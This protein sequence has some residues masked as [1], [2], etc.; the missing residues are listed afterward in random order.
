MGKGRMRP[1]HPRS[2]FGALAR[3]HHVGR[4]QEMSAADFFIT[5]GTESCDD[6]IAMLVEEKEAITVRHQESVGPALLTGARGR[7]KGL[8]E[9]IARGCSQAAQ[10]AIA[11][12][13][14]DRIALEIRRADDAVQTVRQTRHLA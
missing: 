13:A 4:L 9:A 12:H 10:L 8:P 2:I 1:E 11:A 3:H 14:V 7:L 5:L 6:Q